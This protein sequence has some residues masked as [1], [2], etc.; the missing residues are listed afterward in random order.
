MRYRDQLAPQMA[1]Y[2]MAARRVYQGGEAKD[3]S[4]DSA[5]LQRWVDYLKPTKERRPHLEPWYKADAGTMQP[6]AMQYQRDFLA[7]AARRARAQEEF[8][9]RSD[10]A[11]AGGEKPP[12]PPKFL[13]GENRF[14]TEVA[15]GKGPLTLPA[16][17]P[18]KFYT[19]AARKKIDALKA[20]LQNIKAAAPPEPP[21][22]CA[23]AE[24]QPVEQRVFLRGNPDSKGE[25][26]PKRFPRF[27]LANSRSRLVKAAAAWNWRT[28]WPIRAIRCPRE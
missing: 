10:A 25:A 2:M 16:Q 22:A 28:G 14:Y 5:Q 26:V 11:R 21:F 7:E 1:Q 9:I 12:A 19:E 3:A 4:L 15:T 13:A 20:E 23:V 24:D 17:E 18:E 8:R 27:S 6:V